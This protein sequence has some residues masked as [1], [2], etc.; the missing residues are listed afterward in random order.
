[1]E[2]FGEFF[3]RICKESYNLVSSRKKIFTQIIM[4]FILMSLASEFQSHSFAIEYT[5]SF[6]TGILSIHHTFDVSP[7]YFIL[8][9]I[10]SFSTSACIYAISCLYTGQEEL[11]TLK[12]AFVV[13]MRLYVTLCCGSL[14]QF[15]YFAVV[16]PYL[17]GFGTI[18]DPKK[19]ISHR[20]VLVI[21]A[22][23]AAIGFARLAFVGTFL[24]VIVICELAKV[25]SVFTYLVIQLG[26]KKVVAEDVL[27]LLFPS[28]FT[29]ITSLIV[30]EVLSLVCLVVLMVI[31]FVSK[32]SDE[33]HDV[34][35]HSVAVTDHQ[36]QVYVVRVGEYVPLSDT[37]LI[38]D[39]PS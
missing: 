32:S 36:R 11:L 9:V 28:S 17:T 26:V 15:A 1:M 24:Y 30:K 37:Q 31:Y 14:L 13:W 23:H 18:F 7:G 16:I 29:W 35:R 34:V 33:H 6:E 39:P 8:L 3:E 4:V 12:N 21:W 25:V 10:T 38:L 27:G 22:F 20:P 5:A 2:S 19:N